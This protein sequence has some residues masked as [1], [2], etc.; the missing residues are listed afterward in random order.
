[1]KKFPKI[2]PRRGRRA[3]LQTSIGCKDPKRLT[4][5]IFHAHY[6]GK[7]QPV[8]LRLWDNA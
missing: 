5:S 7:F 1:L 2:L 6:V 3:P 8:S 4:S